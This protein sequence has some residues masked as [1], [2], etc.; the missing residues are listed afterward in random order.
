[1]PKFVLKELRDHACTYL[2]K[3]LN[4]AKWPEYALLFKQSFDVLQT[5]DASYLKA[6][7]LKL[8]TDL[9][10]TKESLSVKEVGVFVNCFLKVRGGLTQ[11][12][13]CDMHIKVLVDHLCQMQGLSP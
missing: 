8:A 6:L 2:H 13:E 1:M 7:Y 4:E 3:T 12:E 11:T 9:D 5:K 10:Q